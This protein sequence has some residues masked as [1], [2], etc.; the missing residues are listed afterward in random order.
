M[1]ETRIM[2]AGIVAKAVPLLHQ[3]DRVMLAI[4]ALIAINARLILL[5]ATAGTHGSAIRLPAVTFPS[6]SYPQRFWIPIHITSPV[7]FLGLLREVTQK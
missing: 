7:S 6:S 4:R 1:M 2:Q 5:L 3:E